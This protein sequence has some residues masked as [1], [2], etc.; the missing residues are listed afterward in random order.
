MFR[1]FSAA[2]LAAALFSTACDREGY[3]PPEADVTAAAVEDTAV[4]TD[5]LEVSPTGWLGIA[6]WTSFISDETPPTTCRHNALVTGFDCDGAYCDNIRLKCQP[7][8]GHTLTARSWTSYFSEEP[9]ARRTCTTGFL[10]GLACNGSN[11]DNMSMECTTSTMVPTNCVWSAYFSEEN[12]AFEAP[13]GHFIRSL[14][15][16]GSRCDNVRAEYCQG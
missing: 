15:C 10:S 8:S 12:A 14:E 16:Q 11:C 7:Q 3:R 1:S 6:A 2:V 5:G 9:T 13:V 4:S